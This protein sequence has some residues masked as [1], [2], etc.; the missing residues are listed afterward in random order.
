MKHNE[1]L[2]LL[3]MF[4]V[5]K[6]YFLKKE[7]DRQFCALVDLTKKRNEGSPWVPWWFLVNITWDTEDW[8]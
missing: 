5:K 4:L 6:P 8:I 1:I 7:L 3:A 2:S